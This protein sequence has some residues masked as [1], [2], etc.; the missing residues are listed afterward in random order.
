MKS[1]MFYVDIVGVCNLRCPSCPVGSLSGDGRA[2]SLMSREMFNQILDK[3]G[4]EYSAAPAICLFNW[5]EPLL[6]PELPIIIADVRARGWPCIISSNMNTRRDLA[7]IVAAGPT[8]WRISLS[9]AG[10]TT[11]GR[12]HERGQISF[13]LDNLRTLRAE[14]D[15]QGKVIDVEVFYHLYCGNLGPEIKAI[16]DLAK[17]LGFRMSA[18]PAHMMP[19]ENYIR[20]R[21]GT[22][23]ETASN[24]LGEYLIHPEELLNLTKPFSSDR[25]CDLLDGVV[26]IN[27]DGSVDLCCATY[28]PAQRMTNDFVSISSAELQARRK[29]AKACT[30]CMDLGVHK[31]Y[32]ALKPSNP[33][34]AGLLSPRLVKLDPSGIAAS[35]LGLPQQDENNNGMT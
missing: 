33:Q 27:S 20:L 8:Y 17:D 21:D 35:V 11:Y 23:G 4:R 31:I 2:H 9:G 15:A 14:M 30:S 5:G 25:T 29:A 3:I 26:S 6:H 10:Q 34:L 13:V 1:T 19:M 16:Q 18:L 28:E 7:P 32:D 24:L 22:L 12:T